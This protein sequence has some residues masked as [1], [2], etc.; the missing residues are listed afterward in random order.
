M[1]KN[2]NLNKNRIYRGNWHRINKNHYEQEEK[3]EKEE[4]NWERGYGR[5]YGELEDSPPFG[6]SGS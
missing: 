5:H 4:K 1:K 3:E 2:T 6:I